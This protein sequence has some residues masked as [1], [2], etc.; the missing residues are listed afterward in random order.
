MI[1]HVFYYP[2]KKNG[3]CSKEGVFYQIF[4]YFFSLNGE[5]QMHQIKKK[6]LANVFYDF[7]DIGVIAI[8]VQLQQKIISQ[9]RIEQTV[10]NCILYNTKY[11]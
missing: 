11:L 9:K 3:F 5:C 1:G 6:R 7:L 10:I 2:D 4:H 8:V